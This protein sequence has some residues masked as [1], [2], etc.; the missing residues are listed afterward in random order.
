MATLGF[1]LA[2]FLDPI[3][4]GIVLG[5]VLVYRGALPVIVAGLCAALV[6][7]TVR[8]LAAADHA[9]GDLIV[10]HMISALAQAAVLW[11]VVRWLRSLRSGGSAT[12]TRGR[13]ALPR[14][15]AA[16]HE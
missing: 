12:P 15:S 6:L 11:W 14:A 9:W 13:R 7:E 16:S 8:T 1:V 4:A 5:V 10:P 2:A 3:Q